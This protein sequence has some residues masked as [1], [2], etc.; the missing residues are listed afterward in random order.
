MCTN[1]LN[2]LKLDQVL[3]EQNT[4]CT[5]QKMNQNPKI[6][7]CTFFNNPRLNSDGEVQK[8]GHGYHLINIF[9]FNISTSKA[10]Q[11]IQMFVG[12]NELC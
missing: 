5:N 10:E 6:F 2:Y 11:A 9:V 3:G 8:V 1:N 4:N 12:I 7:F